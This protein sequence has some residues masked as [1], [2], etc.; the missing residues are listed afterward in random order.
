MRGRT[1]DH[2]ATT[3]VCG[4]HPNGKPPLATAREI[5]RIVARI[6]EP[7]RSGGALKE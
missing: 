4:I 1:L 6:L 7:R 5:A 3:A 2:S